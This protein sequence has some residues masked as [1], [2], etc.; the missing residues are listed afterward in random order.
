MRTQNYSQESFDETP[1]PGRRG[2]KGCAK[3]ELFYKVIKSLE[4]QALRGFLF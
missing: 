3:V 4:L 2:C 1:V